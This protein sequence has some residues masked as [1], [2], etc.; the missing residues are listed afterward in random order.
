MRL[1][2]PATFV[3]AAASLAFALVPPALARFLVFAI[4]VLGSALV[5]WIWRDPGFVFGVVD[6]TDN[7]VAFAAVRPL[8]TGETIALRLFEPLA[9]TGEGGIRAADLVFAKGESKPVVGIPGLNASSFFAAETAARL[10]V[11]TLLEVRND[12][13]VIGPIKRMN[14]IGVIGIALGLTLFA[15]FALRLGA[16]AIFGAI[17]TVFGFLALHVVQWTGT[18]PIPTAVIEPATFSGGAVALVMAFKAMLRDPWLMG[19]R[20]AAVLL[21]LPLMVVTTQTGLLPEMLA[22]TLPVFALVWPVVVPVAAAALLLRSGFDLDTAQTV[23]AVAGLLVLRWPPLKRLVR[24]RRLSPGHG[25]ALT[26]DERGEI[27]IDRILAGK[28]A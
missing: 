25:P 6:R 28:G 5:I 24:A 23:L 12:P 19:H 16:A 27:D 26:P 13:G 1:V 14:A 15:H 17:A 11:S 4:L 22:W 2:K 8:P 21:A 3:Y 7:A 10:P 18:I 9:G 20:I